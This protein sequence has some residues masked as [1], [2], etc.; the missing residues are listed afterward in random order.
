MEENG[1]QS[2]KRP[3]T[4]KNDS[5]SLFSL[6]HQ[7]ETGGGKTALSMTYLKGR[8]PGVTAVYVVHTKVLQESFGD[9]PDGAMFEKFMKQEITGGGAVVYGSNTLT[10]G[11]DFKEYIGAVIF[12]EPMNGKYSQPMRTY[13][14]HFT[15]DKM[16]IDKNKSYEIRNL[17]RY[18]KMLQGGG[19]ILRG[20]TDSG[21]IVCLHDQYHKPTGPYNRRYSL[22]HRER[23]DIFQIRT[24]YGDKS[25]VL[26]PAKDLH[27]NFKKLLVRLCSTNGIKLNVDECRLNVYKLN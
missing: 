27:E 16:P 19:R 13:E 25:P 10:T 2:A 21:V 1:P 14:V 17:K 15:S 20:P 8:P 11:L 6:L 3:C 7:I 4:P 12:I 24:A 18:Q 23:S 22:L 5:V 9:G 26:F